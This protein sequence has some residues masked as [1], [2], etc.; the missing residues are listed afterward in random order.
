MSENKIEIEGVVHA[1][2]DLFAEHHDSIPGWG[3]LLVDAS[4]AFNS[5]NHSALLRNVRVL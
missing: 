1:M 2:N 3:A 5:L 4:N